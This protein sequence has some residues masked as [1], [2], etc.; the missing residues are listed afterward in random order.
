MTL[1]KFNHLYWVSITLA[2]RDSNVISPKPA[3]P[4]HQWIWESHPPLTIPISVK[5]ISTCGATTVIISRE[6]ES[7]Y[8]RSNQQGC[9]MSPLILSKSSL[10]FSFHICQIKQLEPIDYPHILFQFWE[11]QI[12]SDEVTVHSIEMDVPQAGL[13]GLPL[14][15][16]VY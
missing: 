11:P 9:W 12:Q 7:L 13:G 8:K 14:P 15:S 1:Y 2:P 5:I 4:T 3:P 10:R 16:W 6:L